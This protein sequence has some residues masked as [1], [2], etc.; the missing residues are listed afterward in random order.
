MSETRDWFGGRIGATS[1]SRRRCRRTISSSRESLMD[2]AATGTVRARTVDCESPA[3]F[4]LELFW[5]VEEDQYN[6]KREKRRDESAHLGVPRDSTLFITSMS[7]LTLE[8]IATISESGRG[9]FSFRSKKRKERKENAH[10]VPFS[11][12]LLHSSVLYSSSLRLFG[13]G[14][15]KI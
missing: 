6:R 9:Q 11:S 14:P 2:E 15:G 8:S 10:Q 1:L 13:E 3:E 4:A 12:Q 5:R 7:E